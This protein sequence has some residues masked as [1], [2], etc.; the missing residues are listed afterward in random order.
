MEGFG[1]RVVFEIGTIPVTETVVVT[2]I[3]MV[4]LIALSIAFTRNFEKVPKSAQNVVEM[5]VDTL[6]K[7]T[8]QT[9][10]E[11][12]KGF[13]P[14]VGTLFIFL[15]IANLIGLLG[16]RPP[17][18][19]VNTTFALSILTFI[20]TVGYGIRSKGL[21][22][23]I[24]GFFEPMPFLLPLNILGEIANPISLSF[25]LFGNVVGGLIIMSLVYGGLA[26]LSSMVGLSN[27]PI[28]QVGIPVV[29]H[30][31]FDVF[32]GVLQSFIF[33]MLTMVFISSAMD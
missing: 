14:Y 11:D 8:I 19:D 3:I 7:F 13:A 18:A 1:P 6:N 12:K 31:Y 21:G 16:L 26:G 2:W 9:M 29:L 28:F 30:A 33:V 27:I 24:K 22:T 5:L 4:A 32:A 20:L 25:R 17:T 23:Y 10:G 15:L